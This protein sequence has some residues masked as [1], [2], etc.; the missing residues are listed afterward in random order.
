VVIRPKQSCAVR[1]L[2]WNSESSKRGGETKLATSDLR[3]CSKRRDFGTMSGT[4]R[5]RLREVACLFVAVPLSEM[6]VM[7]TGLCVA[8]FP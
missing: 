6:Q 2:V 3:N 1:V 7:L 4:R 8:R 5:L